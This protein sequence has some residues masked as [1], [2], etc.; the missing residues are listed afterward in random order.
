MGAGTGLGSPPCPQTPPRRPVPNS[1]GPW[2]SESRAASTV[3]ETVHVRWPFRQ[4]LGKPPL[5]PPILSAGWVA[6]AQG[7]FVRNKINP[8]KLSD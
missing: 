8:C 5:H 4:N 6:G 2:F 1:H 3:P 7:C